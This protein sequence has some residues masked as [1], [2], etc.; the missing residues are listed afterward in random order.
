MAK[1]S[2]AS[3]DA[4]QRA[5]QILRTSKVSE[6]LYGAVVS[7][8]ILAV[9]SLHGPTT[10]HV[11]IATLGVC[12][13]Y[14]LAHVYVDAV[15]GRFEDL[16]HSAHSRLR[17]ALVGNTEILV[18]SLP[19]IIVFFLARLL[20]VGIAGSAWLALWFTMG[21]LAAT[22]AY[23]AYVAGVRG[24]AL[25]VETLAAGSLGLVV[26]GLKYTLH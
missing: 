16:D 1:R 11:A 21:L 9:S 7:A 18:G 25:V 12:I 26:I 6:L 5:Q 14:W 8:S 2:S 10:E 17:T 3:R 13:T 24:R 22:A 4:T 20:G 15:G 19:P 23:A